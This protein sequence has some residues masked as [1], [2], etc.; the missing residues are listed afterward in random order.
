MENPIKIDDLGLLLFLE[1]S[2]CT[3]NDNKEND[4]LYMTRYNHTTV[5]CGGTTILD[6]PMISTRYIDIIHIYIYY[7][8]YYIYYIYNI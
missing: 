6:I 4:K 2:I 3:S 1:T 5:R 7:I 8:I